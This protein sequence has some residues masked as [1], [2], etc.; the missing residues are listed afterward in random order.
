MLL[1]LLCICLILNQLNFFLHL[2]TFLTA[3]LKFLSVR[4][5]KKKQKNPEIINLRLIKFMKGVT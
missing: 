4:C 5:Q 1:L 3:A 2:I